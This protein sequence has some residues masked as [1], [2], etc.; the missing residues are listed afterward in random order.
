MTSLPAFPTRRAAAALTLLLL[1]GAVAALVEAGVSQTLDIRVRGFVH[2]L[3]SPALTDAMPIVTALGSAAVLAPMFALA[4][5]GFYVTRRRDSAWRLAW[6][7]GGAIVIENA[8]KFSFQRARP[9]PFFGLVAPET[10][11]FPSG[12]A[13]F[14][15]CFYGAV[16]W[17]LAANARAPVQRAAI[18]GVAAALV[19][20]IGFSRVYLGVHYPSDVLGGILAAAFW[21]SAIPPVAGRQRSD[22]VNR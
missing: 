20:A 19:G 15:G 4:F 17:A 9:E 16:A 5:A 12:H 2:A 3:A 21:L 18:C 6:A 14:S 22:D 13:L 11:S 1:F 7:M 8:L 10:Y